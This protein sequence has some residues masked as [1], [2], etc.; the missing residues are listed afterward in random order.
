[1]KSICKYNILLTH[2]DL[3]GNDIE[4]VDYIVRLLKWNN[5]EKLSLIQCSLKTEHIVQ[6]CNVLKYNSSLKKLN[7]KCSFYQYYSDAYFIREMANMLKVNS[8]LIELDIRGWS[9]KYDETLMMLNSISSIK[10]LRISIDTTIDIS[11][12]IE[13]KR[14]LEK[15]AEVVSNNRTLRYFD[16]TSNKGLCED[17]KSILANIYKNS[18]SLYGDMC[19]HVDEELEK[20]IME[21]LNTNRTNSNNMLPLGEQCAF[22]FNHYYRAKKLLPRSIYKKYFKKR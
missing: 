2:L 12:D 14:T 16:F 4:G 11:K 7:I 5:L 6:L 18:L 3:S 9:L 22:I 15:I 8:T 10:K 1:L 17:A 13:G 19:I 21:R 20:D